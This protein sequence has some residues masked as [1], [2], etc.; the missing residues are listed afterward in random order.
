MKN[1]KKYII[2][3]GLIAVVAVCLIYKSNTQKQNIAVDTQDKVET[4]VNKTKAVAPTPTVVQKNNQARS[5]TSATDQ[6]TANEP[7]ASAG[8]GPN[9][10]GMS[11]FKETSETFQNLSQVVIKSDAQ[12]KIFQQMFTQENIDDAKKFLLN[13]ESVVSQTTEL[14]HMVATDYLIE[15]IKYNSISAVPAIFDII[16]DTQIESKKL[17]TSV[18]QLMAEDKAGLM[19]NGLAISKELETRLSAA[20]L[21]KATQLIRKNVINEYKLNITASQDEVAKYK[22]RPKGQ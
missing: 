6:N 14:Q 12:K 11:V 10:S 18:R 21:S 13:P 7:T 3:G 16:A 15:A 17:P 20:T 9:I 22:R 2:L 4:V 19:Y 1:N 5:V 8:H